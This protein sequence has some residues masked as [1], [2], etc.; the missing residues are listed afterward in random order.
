MSR[1]IIFPEDD[2][3]TEI[4]NLAIMAVQ[5]RTA[6]GIWSLSHFGR[7]YLLVFMCTDVLPK[8]K[9]LVHAV[10]TEAEEGI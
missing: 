5:K 4:E 10:Q 1:R 9:C 8:C 6:E 2:A 7:Q 3:V